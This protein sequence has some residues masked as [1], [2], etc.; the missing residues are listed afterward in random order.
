M[1]M[2]YDLDQTIAGSV[3]EI[4]STGDRSA[5]RTQHIFDPFY[6]TKE[7]GKGTGLGLSTVYGIVK[8]SGRYIFVKSG[9][10]EGTVFKLL[11]P[12][13]RD[14]ES[15]VES[16][17]DYAE[18]AGGGETILVVEDEETLRNMIS[19]VLEKYGYSVIKAENG[20]RALALLDQPDSPEIDLIVTDVVMFEMGG[21]NLVKELQKRFS[22]LG[23]MYISG[24]ADDSINEEGLLEDDIRLLHKPFSMR[25]FV[26]TVHEVIDG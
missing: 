8:Q 9:L 13:V 3:R 21:R 11:L 12:R 18:T 23:V 24:Y 2:N 1:L 16:R 15:K 4:K 20:A 25:L 6:T 7:A 5:S 26:Q 17:E 19:S 10:E 14:K 22:L